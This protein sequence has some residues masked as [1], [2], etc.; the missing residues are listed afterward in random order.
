VFL[1]TKFLLDHRADAFGSPSDG[2]V[3]VQG[4]LK[5]IPVRILEYIG[6]TTKNPR[7]TRLREASRIGTSVAKEMVEEKAEMLMQSKGNRDVFSLLGGCTPSFLSNK[8]DKRH[9]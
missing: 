3:F 2:Q 4:I 7:I 1:L 9:S 5:Y 8:S 6:E